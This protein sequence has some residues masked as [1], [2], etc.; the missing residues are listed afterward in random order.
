MRRSGTK[1]L[2]AFFLLI[3]IS[4]VWWSQQPDPSYF[5]RS[6]T[7]RQ[8]EQLANGT[9][10][11]DLS[12]S[13]PAVAPFLVLLSR[14]LDVSM[15]DLMYLPIATLGI[16]LLS[17]SII[18]SSTRSI[19]L[20]GVFGVMMALYPWASYSSRSIHIHALGTVLFLSSVAV[21]STDY[22]VYNQRYRH[23][24]IILSLLL[25]FSTLLIDYRIVIWILLFYSLLG[26]FSLLKHSNANPLGIALAVGVG[27]WLKVTPYQY[28]GFLFARLSNPIDTVTQYFSGTD[29]AQAF[30]YTNSQ[31]LFTRSRIFFYILISIIVAYF[32]YRIFQMI[33]QR[34]I[35]IDP[36]EEVWLAVGFAG[37]ASTIFYLLIGRFSQSFLIVGAPIMAAMSLY[38]LPRY[39]S[40]ILTATKA[41]ISI[42]LLL[43]VCTG[44]VS[45]IGA[46]T[47]DH[48]S[49]TSVSPAADYIL[50]NSNEPRVLGALSTVGQ[51]EQE[52]AVSGANA[53]YLLYNE[54]LYRSL[55]SGNSI[56]TDY[57]AVDYGITSGVDSLGWEKFENLNNYRENVNSNSNLDNI[58][59]NGNLSVYRASKPN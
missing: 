16:G 1:L 43:L 55:I 14:L 25:A 5:Q 15:F 47:L 7:A 22:F 20:A 23:R 12:L 38:R 24:T 32:S 37:G 18:Y 30:R 49:E 34:S 6:F 35:K 4:V 57:V 31:G 48:T 9:L 46:G 11:I 54:T 44:F 10:N 2:I 27:Y 28:I 3:S 58:Y 50:T 13:S 56:N 26:T 19:W 42:I 39:E 53:Q 41:S 21:I 29:S 45:G 36:V 59:N 17:I 33:Q 52:G 51:F 8:Y 40:Q